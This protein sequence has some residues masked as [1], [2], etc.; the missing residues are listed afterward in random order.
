[1]GPLKCTYLSTLD[2]SILTPYREYHENDINSDD[3]LPPTHKVVFDP[4]SPEFH[5]KIFEA[6]GLDTEKYGHVNP[7]IL[8]KFKDIIRKYLAA[9]WLPGVNLEVIKGAE[10]QILTGDASRSYTLPYRKSPSE[11]SAI[12]SEIERMLK[13]NTIE[14]S[15]SPWGSPCIL[16]RKP[17]ENGKP[18]PPRFVVDYRKVNSLILSDGYPIPS[19]NNILDNLSFGRYYSK[20]DLASGYWQINL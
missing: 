7:D 5:N 1:M 16:V 6:L 14:P 8:A 15:N 17:L 18:Q 12:K 3:E 11:L 9:F 20:L 2:S 13:M 19:V 10:H 4:N